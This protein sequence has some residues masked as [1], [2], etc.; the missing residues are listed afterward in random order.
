MM[1]SAEM[2]MSFIIAAVQCSKAPYAVRIKTI[3][4]FSTSVQTARLSHHL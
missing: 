1:S 2:N 4:R 3:Q